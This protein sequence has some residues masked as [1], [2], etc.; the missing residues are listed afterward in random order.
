MQTFPD[1]R[2]NS[3]NQNT[4]SSSLFLVFLIFYSSLSSMY[5]FLPPLFGVLF[6]YFI[7]LIKQEKY[8]L[9]TAFIIVLVIIEADKGYYLGI[10]P[11]VYY[12]VYLFIFERIVKTFK[13]FNLFEALYVPIIYLL[14]ILINII[15]IFIINNSMDIWSNLIILYI[16][17]E[18]SILVVK[19][20]LGI[21]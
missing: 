17:I 21:K 9:L 12:L 18:S 11:M 8:Y 4:L 5:L 16:F 7:K 2:R 20:I 6:I 10:L 13:D 14:Y 1:M 15:C 3:L 19:W